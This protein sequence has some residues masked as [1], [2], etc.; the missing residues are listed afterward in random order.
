MEELAV[1][2]S[3]IGTV[4]ICLPPLFK[5]KDMRLILLF[6]FSAN[7]L[8]ATSYLLTGAYNGAVSCYLGGVQAIIN[9]FFERKNK[10]LPV[11]LVVLYALSFVVVNL[12]VFEHAVQ[13]LAM[14]ASVTFVLC[15]GQKNGKK[16]RFWTMV[17]TALWLVYDGI[18][19]SFGPM[20]TH[21]IS[22][23]TVISGIVM[24][25]RKK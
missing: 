12:L 21:G 9:Y 10:K 17:N 13:L 11:W 1:I 24:H 15:I 22:M 4:C 19:L 2:L 6:V 20:V 25:D 23:C 14:V 8:V 18:T 5:G 7:V 3:V 16:Y